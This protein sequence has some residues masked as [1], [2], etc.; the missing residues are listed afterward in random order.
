MVEL[1]DSNQS[2]EIFSGT[3]PEIEDISDVFEFVS[4]LQVNK[5]VL[6][7]GQ[8]DDETA[9]LPKI[10]LYAIK[11]GIRNPVEIEIELFREFIIQSQA[12]L[13]SQKPINNWEWVSLARHHGLPTRLLDWSANPFVAL[14]FAIQ[15]Y[16]NKYHNCRPVLYALRVEESDIKI[17]TDGDNPDIF[18]LDRTYV[19]QPNHISRNIAAQQGWFTIHK[20]IE[21]KNKFIPLEKN[22]NFYGK[23]V[24][25]PIKSDRIKWLNKQLKW[26]G[27]T[28]SSL[29]P[30]LDNLCKSITENFFN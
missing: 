21:E 8:Y 20:Y 12:L 11:K 9:L 18:S 6:F 4:Y 19:F 27:F 5:T 13:T 2:I 15:N 23:I 3:N 24:K 26:M 22:S 14:W 30:D 28:N 25:F 16:N 17:P 29:F 10:A 1:S 7:R